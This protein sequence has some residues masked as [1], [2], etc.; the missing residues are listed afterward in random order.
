MLPLNPVILSARVP[1]PND[2]ES[3][4]KFIFETLCVN[5]N[6]LFKYSVYVV[7]IIL[8]V[9]TFK[10]IFVCKSYGLVI[11]IALPAFPKSR[12]LL[13]ISK[14]AGILLTVLPTTVS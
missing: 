12:R 2:A 10:S 7:P 5:N 9:L 4:F 6:L 3:S 13:Y 14:G 1:I 8:N 11:A